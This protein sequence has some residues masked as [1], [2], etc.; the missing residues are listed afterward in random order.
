[1]PTGLSISDVV[2]VTVNLQPL[3][4][5]RRNFGAML[6]LGS[7]DV[8]DINERIREYTDIAD[9]ASDFGTSAAEYKAALLHFSQ[10][11]KPSLLYIGRWAQ[12]ATEGRLNGGVLS[13][14]DQDIANFT[15]VEA[16]SM[17]ITIDSTAKTISALDLS[18]VTN[19]NGVASAITT[20]LSS[21]GTVVWNANL[22]RF[23]VK[24]ATTGT[25]SK[26][27]YAEATGSGTDISALLGLVTGAASAP[28]DGIAAEDL[29]TCVASLMDISTEW[30]GLSIAT[31]SAPSDDDIMDAAALIEAAS[32]SRIMAVTTQ[33]SGVLDSATTSDIASRV[34][35]QNYERTLVQYSSSNAYAATSI[36]GRISTVDFTGS[37]TTL[38]V[39]FKGE[40]GVAAE[41]LAQS[42]VSA[43]EAKNANIFVTYEDGSAIIEQGVMS[44]G[45]FID[46]VHGTDW[47]QNAIQTDL[48][49]VLRQALTKIP[50]TDAGTN[51]LVNT[52]DK[53][54]GQA[55]NNGLVA[56][57]I[58]NAP[59]FGQLNQGDALNSGYYI[60]APPVATQSQADREARKSVPIQV[61]VKLAGAIHSTNVIVN[62]NR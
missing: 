2:N 15:A 14:A 53:T 12:A 21:A 5:P 9:I 25:S 46:E 18:E 17:K 16:G 32:P 10:V 40:P 28:I 6:V 57:G 19:L 44:N 51:I 23:E 4:T 59:G 35:A 61:A 60:Y 3:A 45:Y 29:D 11:P 58:W 33:A 43:L 26:V 8:I 42:Q 27:S 1:M 38:T 37:N 54:M 48:W 7:S 39:K 49:N 55:V 34:K 36:L 24:S 56:P 13:T 52:I 50:Q 30:Y 41:K 62:V 20:A 22:Q 31:S 47:L